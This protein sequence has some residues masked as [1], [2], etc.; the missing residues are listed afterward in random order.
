[1]RAGATLLLSRKF[2]IGWGPLGFR[3]FNEPPPQVLAIQGTRGPRALYS[4][5]L[6]G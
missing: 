1:M 3:A 6:E 4:R 2:A 5:Y